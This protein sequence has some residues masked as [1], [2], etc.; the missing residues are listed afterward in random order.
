MTA[1]AV[2]ALASPG[3][4]GGPGR[5][6]LANPAA[7]WQRHGASASDGTP[8]R[9]VA[10]AAKRRP[11]SKLGKSSAGG[12]GRGR[13]LPR[14]RA[15]VKELSVALKDGKQRGGGGSNGG[16][17]FG[18]AQRAGRRGRSR[19]GG[20]DEASDTEGEPDWD[21][22][23]LADLSDSGELRLS[24]SLPA[25]L[26]SFPFGAARKSLGSARERLPTLWVWTGLPILP[27][28]VSNACGPALQDFVAF[29]Q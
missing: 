20:V 19:G 15:A 7:G 17:G 6:Q 18:G 3:I 28:P 25:R 29:A 27:G 2:G 10:A 21:E 13:S 14:D 24:R 8:L 16:A 26:P 9:D 22:E 12:G 11:P 5:L 4:Q 23:L 1:A